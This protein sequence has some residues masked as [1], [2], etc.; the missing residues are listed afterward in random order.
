MRVALPVR[1][2]GNDSIR[3]ARCTTMA[4]FETLMKVAIAI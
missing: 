3:G 1:T 2:E 4:A